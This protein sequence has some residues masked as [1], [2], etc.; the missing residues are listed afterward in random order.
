[1][2]KYSA[3]LY[4]ANILNSF[5]KFKYVRTVLYTENGG[6][7]HRLRDWAP[8]TVLPYTVIIIR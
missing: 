5:Q 8:R 7:P 1:M 3:N 2:K 6:T 4:R